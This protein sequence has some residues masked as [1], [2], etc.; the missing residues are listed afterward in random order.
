MERLASGLRINSAADDAAGV[1]IASRMEAQVRGL[2][3]AIRNAADGQALADTAEGAMTEINN[4][5]QRMRELAVQS[6]ND[7]NS[8]SDRDALDAEIQ[9]LTSEIDRIVGTT[10]YNGSNILDGSA[11]LTFQI[12]AN[13]GETLNVD[14]SSLGTSVLGSLTGAASSTAV[15]SS[16][17]QGVAA[18]VTEAK[19]VFNGN[20]TYEFNLEVLAGDTA[21]DF[22]ISADVR[23]GS[24]ADIA[25]AINAAAR[26]ADI[27]HYVSA[28][29]SGNVLT[30]TNSFGG[31][32][33]ISEFAATGAGSATFT[34]VNGDEGDTLAL[35]NAASNV[36]QAFGVDGT[37]IDVYTDAVEAQSA[38]AAVFE[39]EFAD[40]DFL[41]MQAWVAGD[42]DGDASH[43]EVDF[44]D[45][46]VSVEIDDATSIG[47]L[48]AAINQEQSAFNFSGLVEDDGA[49]GLTY[50]L[51]AVANTPGAFT[52][53]IDIKVVDEDGATLDSTPFEDAD[54]M[55]EVTA[56]AAAI[57]A[58][59]AT[60]GSK[61][62][63]EMLGADTYGFEIDG[64]ALEFTYTGSS[65]SRDTIAAQLEVALNAADNDNWTVDNLNGRLEF[66]K[67][68]G[69]DIALTEF[70]SDGSGKI[71]ASTD[72]ASA[73]GQ[74]TSEL[75]DDTVQATSASTGAAGLATAT[76]VTL[77]FTAVDHYSFKV[78][79][80]VRTATVASTSVADTSDPSLMLAAINY[81]L[82]SAGLDTSITAAEDSGT[83]TLTQA[84]GRAISISDFSSDSSGAM[85]VAAG[86]DTTGVARYLDDGDAA[87]FE[88]IS[89]VSIATAS[90]ASDAIAIIDRAI[91]DVATERSKLGAVS[92]R[93][94][95]TISN[96]T[97]ISMN[98]SA[99]QGRIQDADFA[100]ESTQLAKS[101]ILQQASM[102]MLAQAN[103]S[104]QGVLSLLQG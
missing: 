38:V 54:V 58:A 47:A 6:A 72:A 28:S 3:Q 34:T 102:A 73:G 69:D 62:Y 29:V 88:T 68:D 64:N 2:N 75:L 33:D 40:G 80:G 50:T 19:I 4:M 92:N 85:L 53:G 95:H 71:L 26:D 51:K 12:G 16:S 1:A 93:L 81:A 45:Y 23:N 32:I 70:T 36:A 18:E 41:D 96:L 103:A 35:G 25:G 89:S 104:K 10:K 52:G 99:A 74:G 30:L 83:I 82:E 61:L 7:T 66:T 48:A 5:L 13:A 49:G 87:S 86:T 94:D 14:I 27:D 22:D 63:L 46:N 56:G 90:S 44:G 59:D 77:D 31:A 15:L 98:T 39:F 11:E 65:A 100:A 60:G 84:A 91:T 24:A 78:S 20:D 79:D 42:F 97:N 43:I 8:S 9:Q 101:Q 17:H 37:N 55:D 76:E 21:V 57:E 67:K